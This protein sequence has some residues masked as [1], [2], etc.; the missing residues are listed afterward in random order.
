M[1][2]TNL[3]TN[4]KHQNSLNQTYFKLISLE[5]LFAIPKYPSGTRVHRV[6]TPTFSLSVHIFRL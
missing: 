5:A 6:R 4:D 2:N 1:L 3:M